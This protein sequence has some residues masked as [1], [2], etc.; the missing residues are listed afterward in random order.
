MKPG[1][2]PD[3]KSAAIFFLLLVPINL[4]LWLI[5]VGFFRFITGNRV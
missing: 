4:L 5:I 3:A 1:M 2:F